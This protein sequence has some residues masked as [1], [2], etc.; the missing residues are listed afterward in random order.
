MG[1]NRSNKN[2]P[3][4]HKNA[5]LIPPKNERLETKS[6]SPK[7][8]ASAVIVE[9]KQDLET[10]AETSEK[11]GLKR[12][13]GRKPQQ[14]KPRDPELQNPA[15]PNT[16]DLVKEV[17]P[18]N[19]DTAKKNCEL[20]KKPADHV[21]LRLDNMVPTRQSERRMSAE[22]KPYRCNHC[23][24]SFSTLVNKVIH[25]RTHD[26]EK[27]FECSYCEMR[28]AMEISRMRHM[29]IHKF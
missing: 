28:F 18:A 6:V 10:P 19:K 14:S 11:R 27:P 22:N 7:A 3:L 17:S 5:N 13:R 9:N 24:L 25:E 4:K 16:S 8:P 1:T 12:K 23:P 26:K 15:T 20:F 2:S 29:K 21:K